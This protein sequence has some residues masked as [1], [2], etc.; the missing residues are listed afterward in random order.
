MWTACPCK[1]WFLINFKGF[2]FFFRPVSKGILS[3]PS[4][5]KRLLFKTK[6]EATIFL[7]IILAS[8]FFKRFLFCLS[9]LKQN[10][11]SRRCYHGLETTVI[12]KIHGTAIWL[13]WMRMKETK[14]ESWIFGVCGFKKSTNSQY[15]SP[16]FRDWSL[17]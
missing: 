10:I 5:L 11:V 3:S 6:S 13:I 17:G 16:K 15:F 12:I 9:I 7:T 8:F 14:F 4:K 1:V 2:S